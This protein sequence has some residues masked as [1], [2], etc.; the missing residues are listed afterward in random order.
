MSD[1]QIL[2]RPL[3]PEDPEATEIESLCVNCGENVCAISASLLIKS[4]A[5]TVI[6]AFFSYVPGDHKAV[7]DKNSIL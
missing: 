2:F 5:D 3:D 1:S 4:C 6:I 7:A